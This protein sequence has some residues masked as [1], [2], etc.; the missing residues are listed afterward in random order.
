MT[1]TRIDFG[2]DFDK[3][4]QNL[5]TET[6]MQKVLPDFS[7][8]IL[9]LHRVME[10]RIETLF[11]APTKLSSVMIG[12][13]IKPELI[14]K[15]FL[16]YSLQYRFKPINLSD[17]P[18]SET[19][20]IDVRNAIPFR[21]PNGKK[22]YTPWNEAV[23]TKVSMRK[24]KEIL[25]R[26]VKG[27][28]LKGFLLNGQIFTRVKK[29]TW[30]TIPLLQGDDSTGVRSSGIVNGKVRKLQR[31]FGQ[32]LSSLALKVYEVDKEVETAK[33]DI[34]KDFALALLRS[35]ND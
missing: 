7:E 13:S 5:R 17:Y 22:G 10:R 25:P 3:L 35:F 27:S 14:G 1:G 28:P 26:R 20:T 24:G 34:Q 32:P 8:S 11:N 18:H 31:L 4:K 29:A 9:N 6:L 15:T 2:K 16:R 19:R 33:E 21:R 30:E 23:I 12:G